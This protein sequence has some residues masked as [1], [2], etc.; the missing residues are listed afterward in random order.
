MSKPWQ[1]SL[2]TR[3]QEIEDPAFV[4]QWQQIMDGSGNAHVFFHPVLVRV[5]LETYRPLRAL[6]PLFVLAR[7]GEQQVIFPLVLWKRNWKNAFLRTIVP[8]GHSDFDYHD[9]VFLLPPDEEQVQSFYAALKAELDKT[10]KYD[11]IMLDGMHKE[12]VPAYCKVVHQEPCLQ[13]PLDSAELTDGL[14]LPAKKK[15]AKDA[16]RRLKKLQEVGKVTWLRYGK[17]DIDKA[18][19][20]L[21]I[22]LMHHTNR[23]P[24]SYKADG[25][26]SSLVRTGIAA[27]LINFIEVVFD[28]RPIA[29]Q[30]GFNYK[31]VLS[32]YMPAI[33]PE[34]SSYSPGHV[35]L[36]YML[37]C[38]K[39]RGDSTVDHLRGA[40]AYKAAWGGSETLIYD[41]IF[42]STALSSRLRLTLFNL[43]QHVKGLRVR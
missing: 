12:F 30:I 36:G 27:G 17:H 35:S 38:G 28:N 33:D 31:G 13:W 15:L 40:E 6:Q 32:H 5:W 3:W 24:N 43:L 7:R 14:V 19:Q 23:W 11:R 16:L 8:A 26:H 37:A 9:P 10:V 34:F 1:I 4:D 39:N 18:Q 29:W 2:L 41:A 42:D 25:F 20:S 22:M 21:I